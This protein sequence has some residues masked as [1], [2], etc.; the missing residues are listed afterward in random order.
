LRRVEGLLLLDTTVV[1]H[2]ARGREAGRR[3]DERYGLRARREKPLI[4]I[5]TV[6]EML[7]FAK[8]RSWGDEK[9]K[10]LVDLARELVVV[11]IHTDALLLTTDRDFDVLHGKYLRREWIDPTG[12]VGPST[13]SEVSPGYGSPRPEISSDRGSEAGG[14][15]A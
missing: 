3:L 13:I 2:L 14:G 1:V 4:S 12:L 10:R 5:V 9:T 6:G 7:A 8:R 15:E 11:D